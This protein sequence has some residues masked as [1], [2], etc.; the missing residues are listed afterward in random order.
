MTKEAR[1][2]SGEKDSLQKVVLGK[3]DSSMKNNGIR[4]LP[5]D[6]HKNKL[7]ME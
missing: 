4:T 3:L 5:N 1:T 6:T 7:K 2:H